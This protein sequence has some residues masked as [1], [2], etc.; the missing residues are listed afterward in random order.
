MSPQRT[1]STYLVKLNNVWMA[2][3]LQDVDFSSY[4][5]NVGLVLDLVLFQYFDGDLLTSYQVRAKS[6]FSKRALS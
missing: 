3:D 1:P 5:L 6:H 4:A 2:H